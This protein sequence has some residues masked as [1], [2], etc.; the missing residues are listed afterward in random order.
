MVMR[1]IK[2]C[3]LR[4]LVVGGTKAAA[5]S[6]QACILGFRIARD[7]G[8]W[9]SSG[10]TPCLGRHWLLGPWGKTHPSSSSRAGKISR[11]SCVLWKATSVVPRLSPLCRSV[12]LTSS[13]IPWNSKYHTS[14]SVFQVQVLCLALANEYNYKLEYAGPQGGVGL[15]TTR[16][17]GFPVTL[18]LVLKVLTLPEEWV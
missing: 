11:A 6:R 3:S 2:P 15:G 16:A 8:L 18:W 1:A 5:A 7:L 4:G 13:F 14:F 17:K 9:D 12:R 10:W